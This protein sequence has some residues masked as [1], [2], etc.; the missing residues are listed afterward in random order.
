MNRLLFTLLLLTP[1][2]A[3]KFYIGIETPIL[4]NMQ[5][6]SKTETQ[7]NTLDYTYKPF[8][9]RVGAGM[10]K[11]WDISFFY[12]SAKPDFDD[13]GKD[14]TPIKEYGLDLKFQFETA[15]ENFYPY[16]QAGFSSGTQKISAPEG[17]SFSSSKIKFTGLKVGAGIS[18]YINDNFQLLLGIDYKS[19]K[20]QDIQLIDSFGNSA[21]IETKSKGTQLV[22]GTNVWF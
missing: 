4:S 21:F 17:I 18:Y 7:S 15:T 22:I 5:L 1:L 11:T 14:E 20:W 10:D 9:L 3:D 8:T 6:K 13:F 19:W 12:S 16:L 2:I